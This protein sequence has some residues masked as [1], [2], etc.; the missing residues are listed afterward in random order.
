[1]DFSYFD[2]GFDEELE[3][4]W[5]DVYGRSLPALKMPFCWELIVGSVTPWTTRE[6]KSIKIWALKPALNFKTTTSIAI[7]SRISNG[8]TEKLLATPEEELRSRFKSNCE[9]VMFK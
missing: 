1:M 9:F 2:Y 6:S 3:D 4:E 8:N 5:I 7:V